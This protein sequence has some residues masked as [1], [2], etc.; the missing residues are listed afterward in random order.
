MPLRGNV[1]DKEFLKAFF[2]AIYPELPEPKK[3]MKNTFG[4]KR[5]EAASRGRM[6]LREELY[7][8]G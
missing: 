4:V 6:R 7:I 2:E 3:K 1:E 5:G 8:R